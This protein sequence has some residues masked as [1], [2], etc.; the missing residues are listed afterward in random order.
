MKTKAS[1]GRAQQTKVNKAFR[2][3]VNS[4]Y[5]TALAACISLGSIVAAKA[6]DAGLAK[7]KEILA[8]ATARVTSANIP[9]TSPA[10]AGKKLLVT[11]PCS[12]AAEGCKSAV[13]GVAEAAQLL[14]WETKMI[15]PAG[16]PDKARQAI[17]TA[18]LLKADGILLAAP[19]YGALKA[20]VAAAR[21][22]GIKVVEMLEAPVD[23]FVD[24]SV[25]VDRRQVGQWAAAYLAVK[26]DGKGKLIVVHDPEYDGL[27][28]QMEG[29]D[30]ALPELCPGCKVNRQVN[31][32]IA[33]L[34]I[35]MPQQY[36]AALR[37]NPNTDA[38]FIA[39]DPIYSAISPMIRQ[40]G[41]ADKMTVMGVNGDAFAVK[42]IQDAK[43]P[44]KATV[45]FATRWMSFAAVDIFN[46][47]FAGEKLTPELERYRGPIKLLTKDNITTIPWDGDYDFKSDYLSL[48]KVKS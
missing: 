19:V 9:K 22:A 30:K 11:I 24:A 39:Y 10:I 35:Q 20:D 3:A 15:D 34:Q 26:T 44:L 17:R 16:D 27:I 4:T 28:Q 47:L 7:A 37:A 6:D 43:V 1:A 14:G 38:T 40:S 41:V 29:F 45:G 2:R 42:A 36:Q 31:F 8:Q 46:R 48:W 13:D 18:V 32:Q 25:Y 23:G 33:N 5:V 21:A 12:Y